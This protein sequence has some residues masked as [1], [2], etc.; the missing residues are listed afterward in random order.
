MKKS[1]MYRDYK[2]Y[3]IAEIDISDII[4]AFEALEVYKT[5]KHEFVEGGNGVQ[6]MKFS[7]DIRN[8]LNS[9]I[10]EF[11]KD[12]TLLNYAH[13]LILRRLKY[14]SGN[15]Y[16]SIGVYAIY[17]YE[18]SKYKKSRV[19]SYID[20]NKP[21]REAS[22]SSKILIKF[23]VKREVIKALLGEEELSRPELGDVEAYGGRSVVPSSKSLAEWIKQK[24]KYFRP[25][26]DA[27]EKNQEIRRALQLKR[28]ALISL[29]KRDR[30]YIEESISPSK[31]NEDGS[32]RKDPIM[33][34]AKQIRV[35]MKRRFKRV[36][37]ATKGSEYVL[38]GYKKQEIK[39]YKAGHGKSRG[40][41]KSAELL[42][43]YRQ[44]SD[45]LLTVFPGSDG[46][47]IIKELAMKT[48]EYADRIFSK[49][50][51]DL[52]GRSYTP[53]NEFFAANNKDAEFLAKQDKAFGRAEKHIIFVCENLKKGRGK[54]AKEYF[55]EHLQI[56]KM[57]QIKMSQILL[58][59]IDRES[60][61]QQ[62]LLQQTIKQMES[63]MPKLHGSQ[64]RR[65]KKAKGK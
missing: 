23:A 18:K 16:R 55:Q 36:G 47:S 28:K 25:A 51:F 19:A 26:I 5:G 57:G 9:L 43:I 38:L 6:Y 64:R 4:Y 39:T 58:N 46:G 14:A 17:S 8:M 10:D 2:T 29:R 60:K 22:G 3:T 30:K 65:L 11:D 35:T 59:E 63:K 34:L 31:F 61:A 33:E 32:K 20:G 54:A 41:Y 1:A 50:D 62:V 24:Q 21:K 53:L 52:S 40:T 13:S 45:P 49:F 7:P 56:L 42:P 15:L 44:E 27:L 12:N 48:Q 37:S